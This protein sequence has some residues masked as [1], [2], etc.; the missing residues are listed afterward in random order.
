MKK[1]ERILSLLQR[2]LRAQILVESYNFRALFS[3]PTPCFGAVL[4]LGLTFSDGNAK[5]TRLS[6]IE[7]AGNTVRILCGPL[8]IV[9]C[10]SNAE[11]EPVALSTQERK[12]PSI[13]QG[14]T[15]MMRNNVRAALAR[16]L[17]EQAV[18]LQ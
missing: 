5:H 15:L 1:K 17:Y 9:D 11:S 2:S 13:I 12:S 4:T 8:R 6:E 16:A 10:K 3:S 18:A 14:I 7:V